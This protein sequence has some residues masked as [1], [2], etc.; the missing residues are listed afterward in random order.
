MAKNKLYQIQC[1]PICGFVVKSHDDKEAIK[2]SMAH[3]KEKHNM[4][5]VKESDVKKMMKEI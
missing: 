2:I 5:N 4:T 3:A 1:D